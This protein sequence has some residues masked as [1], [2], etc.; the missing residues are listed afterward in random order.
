MAKK[1]LQF[2]VK[3][4]R[5][6]LDYFKHVAPERLQQA[7]KAGVEIAGKIWAD[8]AKDI[9][10]EED[11]IDT[12]LYVNSIGYAS[13]SPADPIYELEETQDKTKLQTGADVSY[14]EALEKR[15]AIMARGLDRATPRIRANVWR[16]VRKSLGL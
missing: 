15:Y 4:D 9:T 11:H 5:Q 14:A 12:S 16:Q 7:R 13:G 2:R 3:L 10:T 8:A 6:A 1:D